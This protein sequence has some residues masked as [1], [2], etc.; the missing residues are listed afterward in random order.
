MTTLG[1]AKCQ[2]PWSTMLIGALCWRE[3]RWW[4]EVYLSVMCNMLG[5]TVWSAALYIVIL[6]LKVSFFKF[7]WIL[8]SL[9]LCCTIKCI[10][11]QFKHLHLIFSVCLALIGAFQQKSF[12]HRSLS[13]LEWF[14]G[15]KVDDMLVFSYPW[16]ADC[17][18]IHS[19]M[20]SFT[21]HLLMNICRMDTNLKAAMNQLAE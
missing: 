13:L 18:C 14:P 9:A 21:V 4:E 8:F 5:S 20:H 10:L 1:V 12:W 3:W 17:W 2:H 19:Y 16:Y 11:S 15:M 6:Y 7:F